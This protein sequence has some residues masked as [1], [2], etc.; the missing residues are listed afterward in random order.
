MTKKSVPLPDYQKDAEQAIQETR[1]AIHEA[2][3]YI[4][5]QEDGPFTMTVALR[6]IAARLD[7]LES[8]IGLMGCAI[9]DWHMLAMRVTRQRDEVI[10]ERD[11]VLRKL[12]NNPNE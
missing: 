10:R 7:A 4:Q 3:G 1:S 9:E 8:E 11:T 2:L 5:R 6:E 12:K